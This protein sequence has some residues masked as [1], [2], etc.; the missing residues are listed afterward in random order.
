MKTRN[1]F[2]FF[3]G[4]MAS[5][6]AQELTG[7]W[8]GH[9]RSNEIYQR[10]LPEDD[11]YKME[12]QIAQ[13]FDVFQAVTYSYRSNTFYGKAEAVGNADPQTN[14]VRLREIK[15]LESKVLG[16]D[17][18]IMTCT[19][20]Y[21]KLGDE[22]YL[23]GT[24]TS[25]NT[26]DSSDCGNG[27][28]FLHK[29]LESDFYE[30]P[31]LL[32]REKELETEKNKPA[33][34]NPS[35]EKKNTLT[36]NPVRKNPPAK[37][38]PASTVTHSPLPAKSN[39]NSA[40]AVAPPKTNTKTAASKSDS[41][42]KRIVH[43]TPAKPTEHQA[44]IAKNMMSIQPIGS[45][46]HDSLGKMEA[47]P[48][49]MPVPQ[50]LTNRSNELV[51]TITVRTP[52]VE[53]NIYDDGVI[54]NDTVSVYFDKKLV[55]SNARL[56]DKPI[57]VHLHI[58]PGAASHELVMVAENEGDIPPNTSLMIVKAGND[59][60]EVRI[61]STEQKNAVVIFKYQKPAE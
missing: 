42:S 43:H 36:T 59:E 4:F 56:T 57:V 2:F 40:S 29:V 22:E 32:K 16:G 61:V 39:P 25:M 26:R 60:Y 52:E 34:V 50:V 10:L 44:G 55:I 3:L 49:Q 45:V 7:I 13:K 30:E 12:V 19:M 9:F 33:A 28:I 14:K 31:F 53:L 5:A 37:K 8:R 47:Q 48:I 18:C 41:T 58:D 11:R 38:P 6:Q 54:D 15:I 51:R 24:F 23:E 46:A 21:S 17:V 27:T 20:R 35:S 1:L